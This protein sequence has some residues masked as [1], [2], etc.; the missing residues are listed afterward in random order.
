MPE[1]LSKKGTLR[2]IDYTEQIEA[3]RYKE[4]KGPKDDRHN[5]RYDIT[6]TQKST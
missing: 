1:Q 4:E 2:I 6:P 5:D 3:V